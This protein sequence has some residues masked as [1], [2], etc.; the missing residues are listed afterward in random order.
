MDHLKLQELYA[1][2][3]DDPASKLC[4]QQTLIYNSM[5]MIFKKKE[6]ISL[7]NSSEDR[8]ILLFTLCYRI[9][10]YLSW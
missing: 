10:I 9:I 5:E 3:Y 2:T 6:K 1:V 4:D 7:C 8:L